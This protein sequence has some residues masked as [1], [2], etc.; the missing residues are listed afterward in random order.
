MYC[1]NCGHE[2]KDK[3]VVCSN[4]GIPLDEGTDPVESSAGRWSWFTM[5]VTLGVVILLLLIAIIAGL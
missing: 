2:V 4:C 1:R 3:A 5:L